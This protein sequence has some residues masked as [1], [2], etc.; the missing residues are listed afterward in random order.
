MFKIDLT[1]YNILSNVKKRDTIAIYGTS[2]EA[3]EI[4]KYIYEKRKDVKLAFF[5]DYSIGDKQYQDGIK[6]IDFKDFLKQK[7]KIDCII[8]AKRDNFYAMS[9]LFAK[10]NIN[11]VEISE[12]DL[13]KLG[14][15]HFEEIREKFEDDI[16]KEIFTVIYESSLLQDNEYYKRY[17]QNNRIS[18]KNNEYIEYLVRS[19]IKT[20]VDTGENNGYNS[21]V[22]Q[23]EIKTAEKIYCFDALHDYVSNGLIIPK[24]SKELTFYK[25]IKFSDKIEM[26]GRILW[27]VENAKVFL[28]QALKT[29]TLDAFR[30]K[31]KRKINFI[32]FDIDALELNVLKGCVRTIKKDRPQLAFRIFEM[33]S[34]DYVEI[35]L[36]LN[37]LL[38]NYTYKIGI[39]NDRKNESVLYC[40]PNELLN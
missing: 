39:Y 9:Q 14:Y 30:I 5:V 23:N 33:P 7:D 16:D 35:M 12:K 31:N 26:V 8:I 40:I 38:W 13:Q 24:K 15:M 18:S 20:I 36:F 6:I 19:K 37:K 27:N 28:R 4:K 3:L 29:T 25:I 21:M 22:F 10:S 32:K 1:L 17:I 11:Y 2:K 34:R